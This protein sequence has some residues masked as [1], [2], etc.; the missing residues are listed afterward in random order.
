MLAASRVFTLE[1]FPGAAVN[2]PRQIAIKINVDAIVV[3]MN[4]AFEGTDHCE[5]STTR[6]SKF[7]QENI[8]I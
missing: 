2:M 3:L 5:I 6:Q 4:F 8:I 7:Y 1:E